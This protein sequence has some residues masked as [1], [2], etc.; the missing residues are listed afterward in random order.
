MVRSPGS[1][2][3]LRTGVVDLSTTGL[4]VE[5]A[6]QVHDRQRVKEGAWL[7]ERKERAM[8]TTTATVAVL[9]IDTMGHAMTDSMPR[10]GMPTIVWDRDLPRPFRWPVR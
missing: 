4:G 5:R 1:R 3:D 6:V 9:G 2:S 8:T 10:A 7:Q